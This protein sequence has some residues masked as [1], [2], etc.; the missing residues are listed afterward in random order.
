MPSGGFRTAQPAPMYERM[1]AAERPNLHDR[2]AG[3]GLQARSVAAAAMLVLACGGFLAYRAVAAV[4]DAQRWSAEAE[5][6]AVARGFAG[7]LS[8]RD[9]GDVERIR[10]RS[11][12]LVEAHPDLVSTALLPAPAAPQRT[13]YLRDGDR[14]ELRFPLRDA[15][16]EA[17]ALLR[18]RFATGRGR[19][20][21]MDA[22]R[23]EVLLSAL[24]AGLLLVI[25]FGA[26]GRLVTRPVERLA[27]HAA[28]AAAGTPAVALGWRRCDAIGEL[29]RTLDALG[30][31]VRAL[32]GRVDGLALTDSLTGALNHR[33]LHD[34]LRELLDRARD[35]GAKVAVIAL[36]ID[37]FEQLNDAGGHAAGDE[38]LRMAARVTLGELRPGDVCGRIGGDE[39][40]LA[41]PDS[42]AWGAERLVDRLR[43]AV[44]AIAVR[45]GRSGLAFSAGI[46]EYPRDA[47][48]QQ[49]LMR[50]ADGALFRAK[51]SGRNRC[52]VYSAF[53][54]APLSLADEAER[55]RSAGLANT[56]YALALAVDLKDGYTHQHSAR[57]AQY[58]AVLAREL[59]MPEAEIEQIRTAGILHDVGKVGVADAVL[60]KPARLTEGEFLEM[61]RHSGLGSDIVQ[62]AGMPEI[63][64]W[65]LHLHENWDGSGYPQG[66]KGD[67]IPLA[68][69]VLGVADAFEAMTSSRLYRRGMSVEKA[70]AELESSAGRQF[71]PNVVERMVDLIHAGAIP[72]GEIG[73]PDV[74]HYGSAAGSGSALPPDEE[75]EPVRNVAA[76]APVVVPRGALRAG[77]AVG[78]ES[79]ARASSAG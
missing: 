25:G 46:A 7:A 34:A 14:A 64:E 26:L 38:L 65:V 77:R 59:G 11:A 50:L 12:S 2:L 57:V 56:I 62:G 54:D 53:V 44:A 9:L 75:G 24:G 78:S 8:P 60:L 16:G 33:G 31:T 6:T 20:E 79:S 63:A 22:G 29:A 15:G 3:V 67:E 32:R 74:T 30:P 55:A 23:R 51:R 71:D 76:P 21:A 27:A 41:L 28:L 13:R 72:L 19:A 43:G 39:F 42:D 4:S 52:V 5:A 35:R 70:L 47:R 17:V 37:D 73:A 40:L 49:G 58:A 48:D 68:S 1:I 69:R 10:S 36:D 18:L 66:L 45:E 61:Q